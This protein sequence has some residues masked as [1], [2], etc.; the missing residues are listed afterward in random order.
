MFKTLKSKILITAIVMLTLLMFVFSVFAIY[1]RKNTKQLLIQNYRYDIDAQFVENLHDQILTLENNLRGLSL[2]GSLYYKTDRSDELTKRVLVRIFRNYPDTLGGGIWFKPYII[3][4]NKKYNCFYAYRDKNNKVIIDKDFSG[5]KYDYPNQE[6]YREIISQVTPKRNIVWTKPYY[7]KI[8]ST[9]KMVTA[10]IGIYV[11]NKLVGIATVDWEISSVINKISKMK[12]SERTFSMYKSGGKINNSFALLGNLNDDS[13]IATSDPY[14]DGDALVGHSLKEIPWFATNL[15]GI[16]YITYHGK[17]YIPFYS[18]LPNGMVLV[19]CIPKFEMFRNVDYFYF[20]STAIILSIIFLIFLLVY[21]GMNRYIMKPID[22]L[23]DIAHKISNGE[24][25][26]IKIDKP[27][28]FVQLASAYDKMTCDIKTITKDKERINSELNIAKAIQSSS[29]PY[30]FPA[31]P[32]RDEFDIYA[33]MEPAR[34]VG[35]D[36]YDFY[37]IDDNRFMFLI[38]DV[39]GKGIPAALFMMTVKTL[40]NNLSFV[41]YEPK[42]LIKIINKKICEN[43]KQGFFVTMFSGIVDVKTGEMVY[44]NCGHNPPLIKTNSNEYKYLECESNIVLGA[45][46]DF[47]YKIHQTKLNKGDVICLYTDGITEAVNSEKKMYGEE[48]LLEKINEFDNDDIKSMALDIK[49]DVLR[50]S[51]N[52]ERS[53][54]LTLLIFKYGNANRAVCSQYK[55]PATREDYRLFYSWLHQTCKDWHI[56]EEL[57]NKLDMCGEEIYANIAFYAYPQEPGDVR[58]CLVRENNFIILKFED[59]GI[60]YNPLEKPDPDINLPPEQ[61]PLG[62]LGI[63]MVKE[64]ADDIHYEYQNQSNILTLKFN[65]YK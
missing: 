37:F 58:I 31:F 3:D 8:G 57:T 17:K 35:G 18:E 56:S 60:P 32:D 4:K 9:T 40:I 24:D 26:N 63:F 46:D 64:M 12:P 1:S 23:T 51:Q 22:K 53:D 62:G 50:Y 54:D 21:Y 65:L 42:E 10:G 27:V 11:D 45:F 16:T 59:N 13:V 55:A 30:K 7:E 43:N 2:I 14:L 38:A 5:E 29:L 36:F 28:E 47:D 61:R 33:L 15:Y 19:I 52:V 25:V 20:L 44:V 6:W 49:N 48:K 34:E 41:G 39:S